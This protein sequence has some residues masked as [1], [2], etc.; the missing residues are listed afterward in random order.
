[1]RR[2]RC[3]S[4]EIKEIQILEDSLV[5]TRVWSSLRTSYLRYPRKQPHQMRVRALSPVIVKTTYLRAVA[6]ERQIT[7]VVPRRGLQ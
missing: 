1:M 4:S 6:C 3:I 7:T 5:H 2:R